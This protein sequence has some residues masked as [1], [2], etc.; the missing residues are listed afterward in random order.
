MNIKQLAEIAYN[1]D[2]TFCHWSEFDYSSLV[3][4]PYKN[5]AGKKERE[6]YNDCIIMGDTETS[7]KDNDQILPGDKESEKRGIR[8]SR[9]HVCAWTLSIRAHRK[10]IC[11]L[12]GH[13]PDTMA[14]CIHKIMGHMS[15]D[16]TIIYF[17]HL[18]YDW[19]FL[20]RFLFAEFG[21]PEHQLNVKPHYPIYIEF[22][23]GLI[24][25]DSLILSQRSLGKWADDLEVEHRKAAGKWDYDRI[26]SQHETFT[27]D[28]LEYIEHDTLA[29]VECIDKMR[30]ALNKHL[31]AMPY[32]ATGIP[33]E[34]T[35]KRGKMNRARGLFERI[36]P[37]YLQQCKL[38]N[39]FHGGYTHGNRHYINR[40]VTEA[41]DGLVRCYD[42]ASSYPY[43][44]I[45]EKFPMENFHRYGACKIEDVLDM[46]DQ[47]AFMFRLI[48][49]KPRLKNDFCPMPALQYSKCV[50]AI[51]PVTDNGRIL[52]AGYLEIWI[53]EQDLD[54]ICKQYDFEKAACLD[55]ECARKDYLPKWFRDYVF[56]CFHNKTMLKGGDPVLYALAKA[57][58]NSL[59][60]MCVQKPVKDQIEEDYISG[61]YD[62]AGQDPQEIYQKYLENK[63][64]ILPYQWG[65]WVTAYAFH[66]LFEL[67]DYIRPDGVWLYSDTDSCYAIG[68]DEEKVREYNEKCKDKIR[69][70]GYGPVIFRAREYWLGVAETDGDKDLYTE[71]RIQGAK[72]YCGR[73]VADGQLH[74]TVAGV[75][76]KTGAACLQDDINNFTT[77]FIFRGEITGKK[78][79]TYYFNEVYE[80]PEGNIT[81]DSIDLSECDY[82][83]DSVDLPDWEAI[84]TEQI[85]MQVYE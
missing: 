22:E 56:E 7:K 12:Y 73:S 53:T 58:L 2:Y 75:P 30:I 82:L 74:I 66:H 38:E 15:G 3:C 62:L 8:I 59:Y 36:A 21:L 29:G 68:W 76:K 45:A 84:F 83:L 54:I 46:Q 23:G 50:E 16:K 40:T 70:S 11:T 24:L 65:V 34:E 17:H 32:T 20:R 4:V 64:S 25:K 14:E 78:L 28:E 55:V 1:L 57:M 81:G 9:N 10:N 18:P 79:H 85:E 41:E 44:M 39:V 77:G 33:R 31:Y 37:D 71:F 42:F 43:C 49:V 48:L 80:D 61:E 63:N 72:R 52:C 60:G 6:S 47:Y 13:R 51:N 5:R 19:V 69:S 27:S 35:R 26:R 67:G